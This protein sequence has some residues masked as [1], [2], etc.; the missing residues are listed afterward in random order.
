MP[1]CSPCEQ[2]D[3]FV[4]V[5]FKIS[6]IKDFAHP[7]SYPFLIPNQKPE[8]RSILIHGRPIKKEPNC[9]LYP[10]HINRAQ[11]FTCPEDNVKT[12]VDSEFKPIH[13][14]SDLLCSTLTHEDYALKEQER[15]EPSGEIPPCYLPNPN[16][17]ANE[18]NTDDK[19]GPIG[20]WATGRV[21]W[22]PMAGITGTRPVVD[23]Y[24][25]TRFSTNE[26]K[27]RNHDVLN[28]T[29]SALDKS[30][31]CQKD[32]K[33]N[34]IQIFSFTDNTQTKNTD[35]LV[36]RTKEVEKWKL[37]L[38]RAIAAAADEISTMEEQ[39]LRL[40]QAL[41]ILNI[42]E[43]IATECINTRS[44]RSDSELV[45]DRPEEEIIKEI[46][47]I[48]EIR[49]IFNR[50]LNDVEAQQVRVFLNYVYPFIF[51]RIRKLHWFIKKFIS[52]YVIH[53]IYLKLTKQ[54]KNE[55][56]DYCQISIC[57]IFYFEQ[58]TNYT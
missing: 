3:T 38:E 40:K 30:R 27:Q 58:K 31:K 41:S 49:D 29:K 20:P 57:I 55:L 34:L 54:Y 19:M 23:R 42:P 8:K 10:T 12:T 35:C 15:D 39:R 21:D 25:I 7:F 46:A 36:K 6:N 14:D 47:L 33:N 28:D 45:R 26:W 43:M 50:T 24:S 48:A 18:S 22:S 1:N 17:M 11:K 16:E 5:S 2:L 56:K 37:T 32:S 9:L 52:T 4:N 13:T 53:V 44:G 51:L